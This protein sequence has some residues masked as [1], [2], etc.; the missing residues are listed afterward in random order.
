MQKILV[1][2][3]ALAACGYLAYRVMYGNSG[4]AEAVNQA[5]PTQREASAPKQTLDNV[6]T[7]ARSI[8]ANDQA[9]SDKMAEETKSP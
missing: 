9:Y 8:E 6:R 5:D 1:T 4:K 7:K 3:G 2:V